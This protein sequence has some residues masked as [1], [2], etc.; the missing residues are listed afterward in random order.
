MMLQKQRSTA[1]RSVFT[2][3]LLLSAGVSF[4]Q[5]LAP[6]LPAGRPI[7]LTEEQFGQSYY[8][9]AAQSARQ[10][11]NSTGDKVFDQSSSDVDKA[12]YYK[13]VSFIKMDIP[14][15]TDSATA[16]M[17]SIA[18]PALSQRIAFAL[19][20]YYFIHEELALAIPLYEK[21]GISNLNNREIADQKFELAYCYFNNLQFDKAEPLFASI[22]ELK[23]GKYYLAGNYYYGLLVYNQNKYKEA[24]QSFDRIKDLKEYRAIVPY[25]IAEIYYFMGSREK[26]LSTA[27]ALMK[28]SDKSF[29][30]NE[31]HLLAAQCL[32]EEQKYKEARPYFQFYYDHADKIRKADLYE[33]GY[34]DYKTEDWVNAIEKFKLLSGAHDSLGQSSMYL[35]GDCYL[36]AGD[37]QGARNAFGICADMTFNPG[38]QESS[39]ILYAMLS[40]EKGYN[41]EA[42][43]QL[44]TMLVTFPATKYKDEANTLISDLLLKTNGYTEALKHLDEVSRKDDRY[45]KVYQ[46]ATFGFAV[47]EYRKGDLN[48][49]FKY[50][51]LSLEHPLGADYEAAAYFWKGELSYHLHKMNDVITYSQ[52]FIT[53]ST[54]KQGVEK[55]SPLATIQHAYLN[56]GYA[57]METQNYTSAQSYFA[58]AQESKGHDD[59]SV[60]VASLRE[61][62][63]V[64]MQKNYGKAITLY[65]KIIDN[66]ALDADYARYQKSILL[67]LQGKNTE[68]ITLLQSLIRKTPPS[69]YINY[70]RYEIAVT[71]LESDKYTQSLS[72]L[73]QIIDSSSDQGFISKAWMKAGFVHQQLDENEKAIDAYKH[74]VIDYPASIERLPALDALKSLYIQSN[75]PAAY[76]RMLQDNN[77]PSADNSS[78]DSTYYAAAE[79]QFSNG[80]WDNAQQAFNSYLQQYPTGIFAIKAHYYLAESNYQL[81]K[82][83]AAL[84]DYNVVL[85]NPWNDFSENSARHAA[86]IAYDD[87]DYTAAYNYYL[88]LRSNAVGPQSREV[89][90]SGLIKSGYNSG[91]YADARS[92]ADTLLS[93]QDISAETI[94]DALFFK[95]QSLQH[96]D[97]G[98]AAITIYRQLSTNKNG[99]IAAESRYH[100]AEI[101]LQQ[102]K[103]KEAENAANETIQLSSGYDYWIVKSYLLLSDVLIKENDYFNAKATLESIIKH[104]KIPELKQEAVKKLDEVK[105]LEKHHSKLSEE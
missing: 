32:F 53:R 19:A 70:A 62:D 101:L 84:A 7:L 80:K 79:T 18:V 104:T 78:V 41:D 46:K 44:N 50:F 3:I 55:I 72:Y 83:K 60:A 9:L 86:A 75:Q 88:Q 100:I 15:C 8:A 73:Q 89:A 91:K 17:N 14:G 68:K 42:L 29:Y 52:E 95:A 92:Y 5:V 65:D 76:E 74:V 90:Y 93:F 26:A 99:E 24:L 66:D 34:C 13:A 87:K 49:A 10:Y 94:N 96:F 39:M 57:A 4:A 33:M 71:Y 77:L 82:Y 47:Q 85:S 67:G 61:A 11:L 105:G 48:S 16:V 28:R 22:K 102:Q 64:F 58:R 21:A 37:K 63:A 43:R 59:Y 6:D 69:S 51:S 23:D 1:Y 27:E 31:L 30:D 81:K 40:Y 2:A 38:Q 25:Y 20:Q 56:M 12:A 45:Y 97:S 35:L 98:D 103:L 36:K 54:G